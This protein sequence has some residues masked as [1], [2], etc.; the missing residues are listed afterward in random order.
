MNEGADFCVSE[1]IQATWEAARCLHCCLF[2]L[3]TLRSSLSSLN[4]PPQRPLVAGLQVFSSRDSL[5]DLPH[6]CRYFIITF[7]LFLFA[8]M[9]E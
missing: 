1:G 9:F 3:N 6:T 4:E 5:L 2:L 8:S 7:H